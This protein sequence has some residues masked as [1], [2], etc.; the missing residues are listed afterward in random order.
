ML[1]SALEASL[2]GWCAKFMVHTTGRE[3]RDECVS[4]SYPLVN[5]VRQKRLNW[6]GHVLRAGEENL[7]RADVVKMCRGCIKGSRTAAGTVLMDAPE[8]KSVEELMAAAEDKLEWNSLTNSLCPKVRN[9][10]KNKTGIDV[11]V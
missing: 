2:R 9:E 3:V 10:R 4:P 7:V 8:F 1:D 11:F 6:L 5:Q